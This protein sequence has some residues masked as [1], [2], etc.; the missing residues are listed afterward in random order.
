MKKAILVLLSVFSLAILFTACGNSKSEKLA[1][2][3][4]YTC[5]MHPEVMNDHPGKCPKCEMDLVKQKM[6]D[7][8]K[9]LKESDNYVKPK[10]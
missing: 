1:A 6:T 4:V 5:V 10:E 9:K 7:E 3:E 8:Q 2:D